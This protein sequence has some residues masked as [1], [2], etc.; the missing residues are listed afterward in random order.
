MVAMCMTY[1]ILFLSYK[2]L[3]K[4]LLTYSFAGTIIHYSEDGVVI[5]SSATVHFVPSI[6][7]CICE[8]P[9]YRISRDIRP[10]QQTQR[11]TCDLSSV[12]VIG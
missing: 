2:P 12:K 7:S 8:P 1:I 4:F 3:C 10:K 5:N 11:Q 6:M 9:V